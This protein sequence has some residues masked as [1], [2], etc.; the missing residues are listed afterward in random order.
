MTGV[1]TCALPIYFRYIVK[2]D[3]AFVTIKQELDHIDNYLEIQ[4]ARFI[5]LFESKI[6]CDPEL[7]NALIPPLL[8]QNFAE[9]AIKYAL[10]IGEVVEIRIIARRL[11]LDDQPDRLL[12]DI[13]DTGAGIP[14]HILEKIETFQKTGQM[15]DGLGVGMQNTI[16]RMKYLYDDKMSLKIERGENDLGTHIE[17]TLPIHMTKEE[18]DH[19][20]SLD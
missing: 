18:Q 11:Q 20:N 10:R 2:N 17:M 9:N 8:I 12:I 3:Q 7:E 19:A 6:E 4:K 13:R 5:G 14:H 15:Q 16:E 1:Q